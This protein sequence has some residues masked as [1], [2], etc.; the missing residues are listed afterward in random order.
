MGFGVRFPRFR[1]PIVSPDAMFTGS[2]PNIII[3]TR[4]RLNPSSVSRLDPRRMSPI[5]QLAYRNVPRL[6]LATRPKSPQIG[7]SQHVQPDD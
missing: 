3:R 2:E 4:N 7:Q 6:R 5:V 1:A